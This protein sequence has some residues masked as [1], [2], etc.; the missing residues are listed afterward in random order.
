M[1]YKLSGLHTWTS[2][3]IAIVCLRTVRYGYVRIAKKVD[4]TVAILI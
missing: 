1:I 4:W 2:V 3:Q